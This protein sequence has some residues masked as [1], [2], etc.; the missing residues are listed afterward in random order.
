METRSSKKRKK[1]KLETQEEPVDIDRIPCSKEILKT[2][3]QKK[4]KKEAIDY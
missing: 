1:I 3:K 4:I 2:I